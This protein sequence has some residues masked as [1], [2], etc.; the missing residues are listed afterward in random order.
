MVESRFR[1]HVRFGNSWWQVVLR[2][3]VPAIFVISST[4]L[5][6]AVGQKSLQFSKDQIAVISK[7]KKLNSVSFSIQHSSAVCSPVVFGPITPTW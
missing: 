6:V 2:R 7:G 4:S 1:G 3:R 5:R